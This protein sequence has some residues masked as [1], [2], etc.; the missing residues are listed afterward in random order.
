MPIWQSD[1]LA[2]ASTTHRKEIAVDRHRSKVL[3]IRSAS[4]RGRTLIESAREPLFDACRAL[5][6]FGV[7]GC[8]EMRGGE[9][10]PRMIAHDIGRR[11]RLMVTEG[12]SDE[13]RLRRYQPHYR[14]LELRLP[15]DCHR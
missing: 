7:R 14:E 4:Y 3:T 8:L 15:P 12:A 10:Y 2:L 1:A 6:A 13:L 11:T 5:I 9:S